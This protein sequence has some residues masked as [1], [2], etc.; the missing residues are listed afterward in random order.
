M[1]VFICSAASPIKVQYMQKWLN[2]LITAEYQGLRAAPGNSKLSQMNY[3]KHKN[4]SP[5]SY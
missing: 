2:K 5:I 1:M 3:E 4:S